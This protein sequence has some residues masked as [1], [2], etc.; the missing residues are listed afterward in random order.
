MVDGP[1]DLFQV[2]IVVRAP[3]LESCWVG[4]GV[5]S[6]LELGEIGPG[7]RGADKIGDRPISTIRSPRYSTNVRKTLLTRSFE[8]GWS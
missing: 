6:Q 4:L 3:C 7:A 5:S 1:G 2:G 8:I